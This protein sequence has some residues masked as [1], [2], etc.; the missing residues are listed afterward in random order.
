MASKKPT[1]KPMMDKEN[2]ADKRMKGD[3]KED[4]MK[5]GKKYGK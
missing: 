2:A 1:M 3:A 4:R 5:K